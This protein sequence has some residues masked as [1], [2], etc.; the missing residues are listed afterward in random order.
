MREMATRLLGACLLVV[1]TPLLAAIAIAV[2]VT[3]PGPVFFVAKRIGLGGKAFSMF[4]FRSMSRNA[5]ARISP[6]EKMLVTRGDDRLTPI[7]ALLR[8]GFDELPQLW[9]V[10][11][12]SMALVGPRPDAEWIHPRYT[13]RISGRLSVRPGITGLAQVL[14]SR[15]LS[16]AQGYALDLIYVREQ[17]L[18]MDIWILLATVP[19]VAGLR[20]LPRKMLQAQLAEAHLREGEFNYL[21]SPRDQRLSASWPES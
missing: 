11:N 13:P 2:K 15:D 3:S 20:A 21:P 18:L 1:V 16:T 7:G 4:K 12:G 5:P 17:G 8:V 19:Y 10:A 9:N 14:G 6:D